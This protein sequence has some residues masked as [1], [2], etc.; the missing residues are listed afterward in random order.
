MPIFVSFSIRKSKISLAAGDRS[1]MEVGSWPRPFVVV[2]VVDVGMAVA[3]TVRVQLAVDVVSDNKRVKV[4]ASRVSSGVVNSIVEEI[5][6]SAVDVVVSDEVASGSLK[7]STLMLHMCTTPELH[8]IEKLT[9][10]SSFTE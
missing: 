5:D 3:D 4:V 8:T 9:S 7:K 1:L 2:D 10:K 6:S